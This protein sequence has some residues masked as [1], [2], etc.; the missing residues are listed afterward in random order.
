MAT[1]NNATA[2]VAANNTTEA[3]GGGSILQE[4]C[5]RP[6]NYANPL[7][8]KDNENSSTTEMASDSSL[9]MKIK[10]S[11]STNSSNGKQDLHESDNK[12]TCMTKKRKEPNHSSSSTSSSRSSS[13]RSFHI[14]RSFHERHLIC[15]YRSSASPISQLPPFLLSAITAGK[16]NAAASNAGGPR[17]DALLRQVAN[18]P[19]NKKAKV[20]LH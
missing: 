15:F 9:K 8:S 20:R 1:S 17:L 4:L 5:S 12:K 11:N 16:D 13:P 2:N 14:E 18:G 7:G 10:R 6:K 19:P 3:G